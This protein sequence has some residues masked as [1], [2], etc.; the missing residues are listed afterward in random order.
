MNRSQ[1]IKQMKKIINK[2]GEI[3]TE[4]KK[5]KDEYYR[6]GSYYVVF[7]SKKLD[8]IY[9]IHDIDKYHVYKNIVKYIKYNLTK[10]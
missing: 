1:K 8:M 9:T 2:Y 7:D 3:K 10:L 6:K 4:Y 5:P